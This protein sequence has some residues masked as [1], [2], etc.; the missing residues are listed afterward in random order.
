VFIVTVTIVAFEQ[1]AKA[2]SRSNSGSA[3]L[4]A[5]FF[6]FVVFPIVFTIAIISIIAATRLLVSK[7][8]KG[9]ILALVALGL[10]TPGFAGAVGGTLNIMQS[11]YYRNDVLEAIVL[12]VGVAPSL[13]MFV[14]CIFGWKR[15][16]Q[17]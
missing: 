13:S 9:L 15:I 7:G 12:T 8:K 1:W 3:G 10:M 2:A 14:L 4:G 17:K 5:F 11:M 6:L 16:P